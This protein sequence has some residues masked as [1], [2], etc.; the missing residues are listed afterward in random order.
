MKHYFNG[1]KKFADFNGRSTRSEFWYFTLFNF[2]FCVIAVI[3]DQI[4]GTTFIEGADYGWIYLLYLLFA[5]LPG[6]SI[7][8]RRLHDVG[9]SGWFY[10]IILIPLIGIIWLLILF[11]S[12]SHPGENKYGV[13]S[14]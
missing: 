9:K 11:C 13:I 6:L 14:N 1:I 12:P 10:L 2:I 3:L 4:L 5:F 7:S 8:I